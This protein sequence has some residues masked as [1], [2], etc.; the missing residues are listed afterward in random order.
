M[1]LNDEEYHGE[2]LYRAYLEALEQCQLPSPTPGDEAPPY[3]LL[4][5]RSWLLVIPREHEGCDS[6]SVNSLGFAG[7]LFVKN[8]QQFKRLEELGPMSLLNAVA[9]KK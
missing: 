7:S 5:T 2:S 1:R 9:R 6:I 3:N 8:E 4:F